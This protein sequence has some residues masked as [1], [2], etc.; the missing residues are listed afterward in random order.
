MQ[1]GWK[2][3]VKLLLDRGAD[4]L[5][6]LEDGSTALIAASFGGYHEIV[7]LIAQCDPKSLTARFKN[8]STPLMTAALNGY[9]S[10]VEVLL[11]QG[12]DV[13]QV[14]DDNWSALSVAAQKG[15]HQITKILLAH[16]ATVE[17]CTDKGFTP[18]MLAVKA[19]H[20]SVARE[21]LVH[22]AQVNHFAFDPHE[23]KLAVKKMTNV[24]FGYLTPLMLAINRCDTELVELMLQ[25]GADLYLD[26]ARLMSLAVESE[27]KYSLI[28]LEDIKKQVRLAEEK[29]QEY[30]ESVAAG[31]STANRNV[32]KEVKQEIADAQRRLE[33]FQ[34]E[35]ELQE[36]SLSDATFV[37]TY[38]STPLLF[39]VYGN[40]LEIA[41]MLLA[42]ERATLSASTTEVTIASPNKQILIEMRNTQDMSPLQLA[43]DYRFSEMV[44]L[45]LQN[46]ASFPVRK[47]FG[48][49]LLRFVVYLQWKWHFIVLFKFWYLYLKNMWASF[50]V[51]A[52]HSGKEKMD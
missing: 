23:D 51:P 52:V 25:H 12:V 7:E 10:V 37:Y 36:K 35:Q 6:A 38:F 29:E 47:D 15:C 40:N 9:I 28:E 4:P 48:W 17:V 44:L 13:N 20:V 27:D 43:V 19:G 42:H 16:Q 34:E 11:A 49:R 41:R 8:G 5:M 31:K 46:G 14:N 1:N 21:L 26:L 45:L 50:N 30:K 32:E 2:E 3:V 33:V 24:Y 18:L 22:G 39:A